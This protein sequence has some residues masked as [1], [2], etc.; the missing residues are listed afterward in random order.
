M[1]SINHSL[2]RIACAAGLC[3][4]FS[5]GSYAGEVTFGHISSVANPASADSAKQLRAG[6]QLAF[7]AANAEGGVN[8]NTLKLVL[9]DDGLD[10]KKMVDL[11]AELVADPTVI[12]LVGW[13]NTAGLTAL[14]TADFFGKNGIALVAPFQGNKNIVEATNVFPFRSGYNAEIAAILKEAQGTF[15]NNIAIVHY[16]VA[17][18]P[19]VSKFAAEQAAAVKMPVVAALELDAKPGG[20]LAGSIAR[21]IVELKR[22]K[23]EAIL[24][25]VAGKPSS[26]FVAAIRKSEIGTTQLYGLSAIVP[27]ALVSSAGEK[28]ARGVVLSQ[29]TPYPFAATSRLVG[30]YHRALRELAP[31]QA[32]SFSSLE[33]FIAGRITIAALRKAGSKPTRQAFVSSLNSLGSVDLG[34]PRIKYDERG[35]N[36]WGGVELVIFGRDGKLV[37]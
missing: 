25:V 24:L 5:I 11:A 22:T 32:R 9:K 30:D 8:G 1:S 36:G 34:G 17:F 10:A 19:P 33:G 12:G 20:D 18:G 7:D 28:S 2:Y 26:E 35:R 31:D 13:L 3:L 23:P 16:N 4:A 27:E 15:K 29:A 21:A 14:S 37:R 6:I